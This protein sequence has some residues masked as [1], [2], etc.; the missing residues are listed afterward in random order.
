MVTKAATKSPSNK[1]SR[2]IDEGAQTT[3]AL[4]E[5]PQEKKARTRHPELAFVRWATGM[6]VNFHQ[7]PEEDV[8]VRKSPFSD[9]RTIYVRYRG[10]ALPPITTEDDLRAVVRQIMLSE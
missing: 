6:L 9:A 7:I 2:R 5:A 3:M 10:R 8:K 4:A 1:G